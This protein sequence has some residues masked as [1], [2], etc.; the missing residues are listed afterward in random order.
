MTE[1]K[2]YPSDADYRRIWDHLVRQRGLPEDRV[3]LE[4]GRIVRVGQDAEGED[5]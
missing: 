1:R 4:D 5:R 2:W 3:K